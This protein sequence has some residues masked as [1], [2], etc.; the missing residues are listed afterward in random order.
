MARVG[1]SSGAGAGADFEAAAACSSASCCCRAASAAPPRPV[2][3]LCA[4]D[5]HSPVPRS[6]PPSS[7]SRR[8]G[9]PR[10]LDGRRRRRRHARAEL[11]ARDGFADLQKIPEA[12]SLPSPAASSRRSSTRQT[13]AAPR[14]S[15]VD[16]RVE[17]DGVAGRSAGAAR[18]ARRPRRA[19]R[20][21]G[22]GVAAGKAVARP[23][24]H[25]DRVEVRDRVVAVPRHLARAVRDVAESCA[26]ETRASSSASTP[27]AAPSASLE[28]PRPDPGTRR[29]TAAVAQLADERR[30]VGAWPGRAVAGE[31]ALD[32]RLTRRRAWSA[33][34]SPPR[35]S[36]ARRRRRQVVL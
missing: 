21:R 35:R 29:G 7:S 30:L 10:P 14:R 5:R 1:A 4:G 18:R 15:M 17:D 34:A 28:Q 9:E 20:A 19:R 12:T 8:T 27:H 33:A 13:C 3:Y 16:L 11:S 26:N 32:V 36:R 22:G 2:P 6:T 25:H 24:E 31:R 23:R